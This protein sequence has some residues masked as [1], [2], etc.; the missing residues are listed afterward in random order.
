MVD[1]PQAERTKLRINNIICRGAIKHNIKDIPLKYKRLTYCGNTLTL[2]KRNYTLY[3][4]KDIRE[5]TVNRNLHDGL[6]Y[7]I[8]L[9]Y[10]APVDGL[11]VEITN[12]QHSGILLYNA[13]DLVSKFLP[14]L[15]VQFAIDSVEITQEQNIPSQTSLRAIFNEKNLNFL[16]LKLTLANSKATLKLQIS[17]GKTYTYITLILSEFNEETFRLVKFLDDNNGS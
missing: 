3:L 6:K 13:S 2:T 8:G 10:N 7:R 9:E 14:Q 16:A 17:K 5:H 15:E 12:I 1:E 4:T 11:D